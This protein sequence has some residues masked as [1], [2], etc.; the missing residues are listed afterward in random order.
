MKLMKWM[1]CFRIIAKLGNSKR[2]HCTQQEEKKKLGPT[3]QKKPTKE[4]KK[5]RH[6]EEESLLFAYEPHEHFTCLGG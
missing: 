3:V 6:K 1:L 2:Q 4:K 5:E